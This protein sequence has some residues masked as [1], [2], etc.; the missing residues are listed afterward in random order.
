MGHKQNH[1][2]TIARGIADL[3]FEISKEVI[4]ELRKLPQ[5]A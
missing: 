5:I 3:R 1:Q 2:L 4:R